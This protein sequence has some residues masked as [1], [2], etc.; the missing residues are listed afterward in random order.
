MIARY[1]WVAVV[2]LVLIAV[3]AVVTVGRACG[4]SP[5]LPC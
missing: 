1:R 3:V 4:S 2:I 5:Y